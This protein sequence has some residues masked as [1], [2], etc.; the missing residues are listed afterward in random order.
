M[1]SGKSSNLWRIQFWPIVR[2]FGQ[3]SVLTPE[4]Q[5]WKRMAGRC[6]HCRQPGKKAKNR[7]TFSG[8]PQFCSCRRKR[9][10]TIAAEVKEVSIDVGGTNWARHICWKEHMINTSSY[11]K[12]NLKPSAC[13]QGFDTQDSTLVRIQSFRP[14]LFLEKLPWRSGYLHDQPRWSGWRGT[15][16]YCVLKTQG[17]AKS[18]DDV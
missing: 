14:D 15:D 18:T 2:P 1:S 8:Q 3:W 5:G 16:G 17:S 12:Q 13:S 10:R 7:Q 6:R 9:A 11:R 4:L